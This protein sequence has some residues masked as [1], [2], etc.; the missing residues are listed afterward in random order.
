M[1]QS[2]VSAF[3]AAHRLH[4]QDFLLV[5]GQATGVFLTHPVLVCFHLSCEV[6]LVS[7]GQ[8]SLSPDSSVIFSQAR[9]LRI[10]RCFV[11]LINLTGH[12]VED[13]VKLSFCEIKKPL[14]VCAMIFRRR[15]SGSAL[16]SCDGLF[17]VSPFLG[18]SVQK[19]DPILFWTFL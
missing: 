17:T 2:S 15:Q 9:S 3:L 14:R 6:D 13:R 19:F 18:P 10:D 7:H 8:A 4:L 1:I 16:K 11:L 12:Q 5:M